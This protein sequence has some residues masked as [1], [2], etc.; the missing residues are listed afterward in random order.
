MG[1]DVT[2]Q[3]PPKGMITF[4]TL[5]KGG[6]RDEIETALHDVGQSFHNPRLPATA[7][8]RIVV[9]ITTWRDGETNC[10][11]GATRVHTHLPDEVPTPFIATLTQEGLAERQP[12]LPGTTPHEDGDDGADAAVDAGSSADAEPLPLSGWQN[13]HEPLHDRV[14]LLLRELGSMPPA[15]IA[16]RLEVN[17]RTMKRELK[18]MLAAKR[19][20]LIPADATSLDDATAVAP[21]Y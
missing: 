9:E 16:S 13:P 21:G 15:E 11:K 5:L 6:V 19:I 12:D 3:P 8:R 17:P 20:K 1:F 10:I 18:A 14:E 7:K 2:A 4:E